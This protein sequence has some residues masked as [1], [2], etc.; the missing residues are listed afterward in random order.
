[1]HALL[2]T[3][4]LGVLASTAAAAD[5]SY[6]M[7]SLSYAPNFC[8]EGGR[9]RNVR[10]CSAGARPFVVHGLWPQSDSGRGP[11]HCGPA[12][13]VAADL[14]RTMLNYIPTQSLIQHEWATHGTCSG[15]PAGEYFAALRKLADSIR[16]PQSVGEVR[17]RLETDPQSVENDF[18]QA[19]PGIP[20]DGFRVSCYRDAGLQ[21]VRI[22]FDK[23]FQ[24]TPCTGAGECSRP[25]IFLLPGRQ[26]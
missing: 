26:R 6:Y 8:A 18:A 19:N 16:I 1:M 20:R 10:E 9:N 22:C 13:P 12:R 2:R 21:E 4:V 17:E 14:V 5:F 3:V 11:E 24:A 15:L 25:R 23:T 7:L